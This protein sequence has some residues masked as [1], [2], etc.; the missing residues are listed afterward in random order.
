MTDQ[1]ELE[2]EQPSKSQR[3]REMHELRDLGEKLVNLSDDQISPIMQPKILFAIQ[4]CRRIKKGN[5]KKRQI[6]YI[7]KLLR[8]IDVDEIKQLIDRYDASSK[9]HLRQFHQLEL[10]RERLINGDFTALDEI[11]AEFPD[12][13]RQAIKQL[14]R[15]AS[16]E[17][18]DQLK[19]ENSA[20]PIHFRKLFKFLKALLDSKAVL[21]AETREH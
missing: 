12:L 10:W 7:G 17:R 2:D 18:E 11:S 5:A 21:G 8:D 20:A 3:K 13:D 19:Q 9:S 14:I 6:S 4:E 15:K 16:K 1:E